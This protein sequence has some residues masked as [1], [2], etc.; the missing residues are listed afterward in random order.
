MSA[1]KTAAVRAPPRGGAVRFSEGDGALEGVGVGH[2]AATA[3]ERRIVDA[4]IKRIRNS[5]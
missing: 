4:M 3:T 5:N 2:G 1:A